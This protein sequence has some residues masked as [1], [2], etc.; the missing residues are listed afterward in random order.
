MA[1]EIERKFL[2]VGEVS[3]NKSTCDIIQG[4]LWDFPTIR[5]RSSTHRSS[6]K[7]K[8]YFTLKTKRI[9]F[10]CGEWE[11]RIPN[12]VASVLLKI[13]PLIIRKSRT[14]VVLGHWVWEVDK[15]K[16]IDLNIAEI[17]LPTEDQYLFEPYWV[18]KEVSTDMS[19]TNLNIAKR[20][21][22]NQIAN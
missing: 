3:D 13:S 14:E 9:K 7:T 5:I 17:E 15:F 1:N 10:T 6:Q 11:F 4:Y 18:G 16:D 2:L 19:Y 20:I 8:S 21:K 12:L 22:E